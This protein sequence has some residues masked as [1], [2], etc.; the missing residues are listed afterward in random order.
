MRSDTPG[1]SMRSLLFSAS[2]LLFLLGCPETVI[3]DPPVPANPV[4][5]ASGN[6]GVVVTD[7]LSL[8]CEGAQ[9]GDLF[10]LQLDLQLSMHRSGRADAVLSGLQLS[11]GMAGGILELDG[12]TSGGGR[13]QSG[14]DEGQPAPACD[15]DDAYSNESGESRCE[16]DDHRDGEE[17]VSRP[18][19][20][21]RSGDVSLEVLAVRTDHGR[22][23]LALD[24]RDCH[25]EVA[26]EVQAL[27]SGGDSP[28][29]VRSSS[30]PES[31][32]G[33]DEEDDC[34]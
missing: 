26:V 12:E 27:G 11:G 10:G 33:D 5:L 32:C 7:V 23:Y 19:G 24:Q 15:E 9:E 16:V 29:V 8:D 25:I 31:E 30:E 1:L 6:Y 14:D 4:R 34:G 3:V 20:G 13:A 2:S 22:G 18:G 21:R 17:D 28:P